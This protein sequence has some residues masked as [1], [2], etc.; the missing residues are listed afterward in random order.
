MEKGRLSLQHIGE[1]EVFPPQLS[2]HAV[3]VRGRLLYAT[4][5]LA[6]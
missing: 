5:G 3:S 2:A 1:G 4:R 6:E